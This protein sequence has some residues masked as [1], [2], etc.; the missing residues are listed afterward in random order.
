MATLREALEGLGFDCYEGTDGG[1]GVMV[2]GY[3][4]QEGQ[5]LPYATLESEGDIPYD[6]DD[7]VDYEERYDLDVSDNAPM[8]LWQFD[9]AREFVEWYTARYFPNCVEG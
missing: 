5:G 4:L 8:M 2:N 9:T 6:W 7:A 1:C 3:Y